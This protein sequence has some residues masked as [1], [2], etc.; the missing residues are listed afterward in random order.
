M[1]RYKLI[2]G[3]LVVLFVFTFSCRPEG[4]V[5]RADLQ[6]FSIRDQAKIGNE[7]N[8]HIMQDR[9]RYPILRPENHPILHGYLDDVLMIIVNTMGVENRD[10]FKWEIH[11][12]DDEENMSTYTLPGGK[13]FIT[14]GFL[15]FLKSE[16]Q[17]VAVLSHEMYY[18]D[19]SISMEVLQDNFSGLILG[20][21]LFNNP[22][23][24]KDEMITTLQ[25]DRLERSKVLEADL[26]SIDL[27]CQF[28]Y[29][30][31]V[32]A[33]IISNVNDPDFPLEW[34]NTR[35]TYEGRVD[36]ILNRTANCKP[37]TIEETRYIENV[38]NQL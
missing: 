36:T 32:I 9:V 22:V 19:N 27:M 15:K 26:Y 30:K 7:L 33:S 8:A 14:S 25:Q 18:A 2:L 37:G 38:L 29:E 6:E 20:D 10:D 35:P 23:M 11:V 1:K 3:Y 16:A 24:E 5:V 34:L 17:L 28:N 31:D 4:E 21:I 12:V 13:L